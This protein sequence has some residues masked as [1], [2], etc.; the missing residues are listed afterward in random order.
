MARKYPLEIILRHTGIAELIDAEDSTVWSSDADAD[1]K[2]EVSQEFLTEDDVDDILAYL[3]D[4]EILSEREAVHF[5]N[6]EWEVTEESLD[7]DETDEDVE[8]DDDDG[9]FDEEED[10]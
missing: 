10:D 5:E 6:G 8:T 7:G 2:D 4:K 3:S 9:E 1:F